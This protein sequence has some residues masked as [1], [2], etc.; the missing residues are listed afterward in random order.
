M[1]T[2]S[3]LTPESV[4]L[5]GG[6][7]FVTPRP[8]VTP[9]ALLD[10]YNFEVADRLG[11][12]SMDGIERFDGS[13][14]S[15]GAF[16]SLYSFTYSSLKVLNAGEYLWDSSLDET[17]AFGVVVSI[18]NV[19]A[20][21]NC[22]NFIVTDFN[23]FSDVLIKLAADGDIAFDC[24]N[25]TTGI[26]VATIDEY[27]RAHSSDSLFV[28]KINSIATVA[29]SVAKV[30]TENYNAEAFKTSC[31]TVDNTPSAQIPNQ[32]IGLHWFKE[33][34]YAVNDLDSFYFDTGS[35]EILPNDQ[36]TVGGSGTIYI[37]RDIVVSS[38]LGKI[39]MLLVRFYLLI[40][41]LVMHNQ[42]VFQRHPPLL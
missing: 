18:E 35:F 41:L 26:D 9:G 8:S 21:L 29:D 16:N 39:A 23:K 40:I 13:V 22:A 34:L 42:R 37:V 32:A 31:V 17:K 7:D 38:A 33:H 2:Q 24:S 10:C 1:P 5:I 12:K 3:L 25:S 11:Y 27:T 20:F 30:S 28:P 6:L 15:S 19:T 4:Q 36:I 14:S